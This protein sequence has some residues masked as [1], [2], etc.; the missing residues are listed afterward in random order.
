MKNRNAVLVFVTLFLLAVMSRWV[1]HAW[2]FT[3][4][5][6][7]FLFA[8]AY[9]QDKKVAVALMLSA[10]LVSDLFIGFHNQMLT[11]YFSYLIV[12]ALG[13]LLS[14]GAS[15]LKIAGFALLGSTSFYLISNFGVW[16]GGGLY[17]MTAAGL[18]ECYV[19]AIPFYR[20][21]LVSDVVSAVAIFEVAK[22]V[23]VFAPAPAKT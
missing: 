17:P 16:Y 20:N 13:F 21:Q 5:G 14:T 12:V 7:A 19:M 22:A 1:G 3:I 4:V 8:G 11:V 2:N 6:G 18:A 10:M 9:F 23:G 15:R